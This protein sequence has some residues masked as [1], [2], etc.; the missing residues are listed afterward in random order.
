MLEEKDA[1]VMKMM[2]EI[3]AVRLEK[4]QLAVRYGALKE[5]N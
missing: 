2:E 5:E 1:K 3:S 4:E